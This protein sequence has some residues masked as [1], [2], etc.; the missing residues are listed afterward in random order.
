MDITQFD[1]ITETIAQAPNRRDVLRLLGAAFGVGGLT[2]LASTEGETKRR[3][4]NK[5]R[6]KQQA[7]AQNPGS[8]GSSG[9]ICSDGHQER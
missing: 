8:S 1:R 4:K 9:P 5:K 6:K 3:R 7:P 2:L